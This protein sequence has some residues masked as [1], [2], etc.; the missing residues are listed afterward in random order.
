M[1]RL[2]LTKAELARKRSALSTYRRFLP[3][4]D[5]KRR[6]L[7]AERNRARNELRELRRR[8]DQ[9]IEDAG[10][11]IP[12]LADLTV[13]LHDLLRIEGVE[14]TERNV[15]G[16]RLPVVARVVTSGTPYG[17]LTRPHW[18]DVLVERLTEVI[19]LEV[20]ERIAR[21]RLRL[22]DDAL[23]KVTQRVNLFD[24]VLVPQAERDIR[25]IRVHLGDAERAA[26]VISKIAKS[27]GT[28]E[29]P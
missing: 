24:K 22:L 1:A 6:Q 5:L 14:V 10:R 3:S 9:R 7:L 2:K 23:I 19:R 20:E 12:M 13:E 16:V 15:L 4:L 8:I 29:A 27:R 26:V 17:M 21:E 11:A 28:A 18:L 25:R